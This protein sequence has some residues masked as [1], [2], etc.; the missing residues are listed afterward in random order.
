MLSIQAPNLKAY[1]SLLKI[2][3][4]QFFGQLITHGED[5]CHHAADGNYQRS[6]ISNDFLNRCNVV[7]KFLQNGILR[8]YISA[9]CCLC[10]DAGRRDRAVTVSINLRDHFGSLE[11][12]HYSSRSQCKVGLIYG[13]LIKAEGTS[14]VL[15]H[16]FGLVLEVYST[17]Y[18]TVL[19]IIISQAV[20]GKL[21]DLDL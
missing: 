15:G 11:F 21:R 20:H 16:C 18:K 14:S 17:G 13:I 9:R 10:L 3:Y 4:I 1:I 2:C 12:S 19:S 8:R 5:R 7:V 6:I